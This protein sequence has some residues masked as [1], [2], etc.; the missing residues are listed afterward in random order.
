MGG[1]AP[2]N[3]Q[4]S[5]QMAATTGETWG[6]DTPGDTSGS[7]VDKTSGTGGAL[8]DGARQNVQSSDPVKGSVAA[9]QYWFSAYWLYL[10]FSLAGLWGLSALSAWVLGAGMGVRPLL[11][12]PWGTLIAFVIWA[13]AVVWYTLFFAPP[14]VNYPWPFWMTLGIFGFFIILLLIVSASKR[15]NTI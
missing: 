4:S 9:F 13:S 2:V 7:A 5:T 10:L 11:A 12:P 6:S 14:S 15:K 8:E 3:A 1:A